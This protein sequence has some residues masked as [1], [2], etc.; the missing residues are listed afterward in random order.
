M[1]TVHCTATHVLGSVLLAQ[2]SIDAS[3]ISLGPL[4]CHVATGA[5]AETIESRGGFP[6]KCLEDWYRQTWKCCIDLYLRGLTYMSHILVKNMVKII[7][8]SSIQLWDPTY[9]VSNDAFG[10]HGFGIWNLWYLGSPWHDPCQLLV[11]AAAMDALL[12]AFRS[13]W[14]AY[15]VCNTPQ[16][17]TAGTES[18]ESWR[19]G[20][21]HFSSK[22][23]GDLYIGSMLIFQGVGNT[24]TWKESH[25]QQCW[26]SH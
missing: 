14:R 18:W 2:A 10:C 22:K 26:D 25:D 8:L 21:D 9:A 5:G 12:D 4:G 15:L 13:W 23:N 1:S 16:K 24:K 20:F 7:Q 3:C 11:G 19:F 6:W 17:P